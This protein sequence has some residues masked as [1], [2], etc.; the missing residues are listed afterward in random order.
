MPQFVFRSPEGQEYVVD[1]P[2]GATEDEAWAI[3]QQQLASTPSAPPQETGFFPGVEQGFRQAVGT[4]L[5]GVGELTGLEGLA[6]AGEEFG[7][8]E[9]YQPISWEETK[10]AYDEGLGEGLSATG[11][12]LREQSGQVLGG[13]APYAATTWAGAK[14]GAALMPLPQLKPIAGLAGAIA[15][16]ALSYFY[17]EDVQRQQA[18][19]EAAIARGETPPEMPGTLETLGYAGLQSGA[20]RLG[21]GVIGRYVPGINKLL[22]AEGR[23]VAEETAK[24]I[25]QQG[26]LKTTGKGAAVGIATEVPVELTQ[27]VLERQAANLPLTG[28]EANREYEEVIAATIAGVAPLG[29]VGGVA[30]RASARG[31]VERE[32]R[33]AQQAAQK[34]I[35]QEFIEPEG[36][37]EELDATDADYGVKT[38]T[39]GLGRT[40]RKTG[41]ASN[42][43]FAEQDD[44]TA[45]IQQRVQDSSAAVTI[46]R[47][48]FKKATNEA[49][50]QAGAD[51]VES[52]IVRN[53]NAQADAYEHRAAQLRAKG[54]T[55]N[56]NQVLRK[57]GKLR[58]NARARINGVRD[59]A[60]K[61][62]LLGETV[63]KMQQAQQAQA[64][65][66]PQITPEI[67]DLKLKGK[68]KDQLAQFDLSTPEGR[69]GAR[70]FLEN[71]LDKTTSG[72]M[73][74]RIMRS[75]LKLS[76][77]STYDA[78]VA[79]IAQPAPEAAAAPEVAAAPEAAPVVAEEVEEPTGL[80][81][82]EPLP[83]GL[84]E[85]VD[86][87]NSSTDEAGRAAIR[88]LA[89]S[90][91]SP[92][93]VAQAFE[94]VPSEA[95]Q[96]PV[97]V[98]GVPSVEPEVTDVQQPAG[99]GVAVAGVEPQPGAA[100]GVTAPQAGGVARGGGATVRDFGGV[101]REPST[102]DQTI[103]HTSDENVVSLLNLFKAGDVN[104]ALEL[105]SRSY[106]PLIAEVARRAMIDPPTS[107]T[108]R[109]TGNA[110][111]QYDYKK[112]EVR[113]NVSFANILLEAI[114]QG[115]NGVYQ[116]NVTREEFTA[117]KEGWFRTAAHELTHHATHS[118][119]E[120]PRT[121]AQREAVK[122]LDN[123][124]RYTRGIA[125]KDGR[126]DMYGFTTIHE[127]ISDGMSDTKF[128]DYLNSIQYKGRS[129]WTRFV[130]A[131]ADILGLEANTAFTELLNAYNVIAPQ[132]KR[133]K[134]KAAAEAVVEP[135]GE[136][137][138]Q[139]T[140]RVGEEPAGVRAGPE[141]AVSE[142]TPEVGVSEVTKSKIEA[143]K[144]NAMRGITA[145]HQRVF[146]K[147]IAGTTASE[148]RDLI[149]QV[150]SDLNPVTREDIIEANREVGRRAYAIFR[151][152]A[153]PAAVKA[154]TERQ[155][156]AVE[157]AARA[158]AEAEARIKAMV[159]EEVQ[160]SQ[161][162]ADQRRQRDELPSAY[163]VE[164]APEAA[165]KREQK[166]R[167]A[168]AIEEVLPRPQRVEGE[169]PGIAR[170]KA[171]VERVRTRTQKRAFPY[172]DATGFI[173]SLRQ[174]EKEWDPRVT[175]IN[176]IDMSDVE[177]F[178][179][180]DTDSV[181]AEYAD[182][183]LQVQALRR[184]AAKLIKLAKDEGEDYQA[185]SDALKIL[186]KS[187]SK[188]DLTE[189]VSII[190]E[191]QDILNPE[192]PTLVF[193]INKKAMEMAQRLVNGAGNEVFVDDSATT[194]TERAK[195]I[196]K[197][198]SHKEDA[199]GNKV[200]KTKKDFANDGRSLIDKAVTRMLSADAA[201]QREA[202]RR[203][204]AMT[205]N[206]AE[207]IGRALNMS[208]S[209]AYHAEALASKF[210]EL[211][212]LKYDQQAY[213]WRAEESAAN[214][215]EL[216]K[217]IQ[218]MAEKN[219]LDMMMGESLAHTYLEAARLN[220]IR[221]EEILIQRRVES[222]RKRGRPGDIKEA[223]R[224]Q[225][226][227]LPKNKKTGERT[228]VHKSLE[229]INAGLKIAEQY[230][231]V[232][233]IAETWNQIR[234]NAMK[235]VEQSGMVSAEQAEIWLDNVDYVPFY[236]QTQ[237]EAGEGPR[238][239]ISGLVSAPDRKR[240]KGTDRP[241]NNVFDNMARWTEYYIEAAVRNNSARQMMREMVGLGMA[242]QKVAVSPD[243]KA[244]RAFIWVDG[245]KTEFVADDPVWLEAFSGMETAGIPMLGMAAKFTNLLRKSVVLN[246]IFSLGQLTQ[247]SFG[248]MLSSGLP[249]MKA[250]QLPFKVIKEFVKTLNGTSKAHEELT[251][252]GTVGVKDYSAAVVR[253]EMER[254]ATNMRPNRA[255]FM[256]KAL[257]SAEHFSM[258][259]DN[260]VRQA[261]YDLSLADGV[262]KAE[263]IER[264]FEV[265]N[266]RRKGSSSFVQ[267]MARTVPFFNAYLQALNVQMNVLAGEG[268]SPRNKAQW[269]VLMKNVGM[270]VA[271]TYMYS[272]LMSGDDDYEELD[273]PM[274]DRM[275][276]IPGTG[277]FG[278]PL[279]TDLFLL[280]KILT[281]HMV[282]LSMDSAT[283]DAETFKRSVS[284]ALQHALFSPTTVPQ[285]FKPT[286]EWLLDYN[287]YTGR[288]L[289]SQRYA[290]LEPYL[291]YSPY[292]SE[293]SKLIGEGLDISPIK[294][295]NWLRGTFGS[296]AGAVLWSSNMFGSLQGVR[297]SKS[298][299]DTMATFPGLSRFINK[300]YG[301]GMRAMYYDMAREVNT[302]YKSYLNI[303]ANDPDSL[304][305][306]LARDSNLEKV[307][308]AKTM[309]DLSKKLG[310]IRK[311]QERV[312]NM[313]DVDPA[314]KRQIIEDL[315]EYE[316]QLLKSLDLKGMRK[317]I[318]M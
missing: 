76:L 14:T 317:F 114:R 254:F 89:E 131:I 175:Y 209:Q 193:S 74:D 245:K 70:D 37:E 294:L 171:A 13:L 137:A 12:F 63:S 187:K 92:E 240:L 130:Q 260:A 8:T 252:Y 208:T 182:F 302:A 189:A 72:A 233:Q 116:Q 236:R 65:A 90:E 71:I 313:R 55:K 48:N 79:A 62:A 1:G 86:L 126:A 290:D 125:K 155:Q 268:I 123:L 221:K 206:E 26:I 244:R 153:S 228:R 312:T 36:A 51:A 145:M 34:A 169:E 138:V 196:V 211:G 248:A 265:I 127:F 168:E 223:K 297:P 136:P 269:G 73:V 281:E 101:G 3:L 203:V 226:I 21:L 314:E 85:Y 185:I 17:G 120:N 32:E 200:P 64:A 119:I 57:A 292:T 117:M 271:M 179:L 289:V 243:E 176:D 118:V 104:G 28:P 151:E 214:F 202:R 277:G 264:A 95:A 96:E 78:D 177:G 2:E 207:I 45:E 93:Q 188:E 293:L 61:T 235:I 146:K 124:Y 250:I 259:S 54:A 184:K 133:V 288:Q 276:M 242:E 38:S 232:E 25:A 255:G 212:D 198:Y 112:K 251:R 201:A 52:A 159:A 279:R 191:Y 229:Q 121:K 241:V 204:R 20:E 284:T 154:V 167:T 301:S 105:I 231:E 109:D 47:T 286:V 315:Q 224:L 91:Y 142:A 27:T 178:T 305:P 108:L 24:R 113:L 19:R 218:I 166:V 9:G 253:E 309:R 29:G 15:A 316:R 49:D 190:R 295:D 66:A 53:L 270:V 161:A 238:E 222:L 257:R 261:I 180:D 220:S 115:P 150:Y 306:F 84:Q 100:E 30:Q 80:Q 83:I 210:L 285:I 215:P 106:D 310:E 156:K 139:P 110:I 94:G 6:K 234:Q 160:K 186:R 272:M 194:R 299:Q 216:I 111:G 148:M 172:V 41:V 311:Q 304:D 283:E 278:I 144:D 199:Q 35:R 42:I 227:Y 246:P 239:Y 173:K 68:A 87:Y 122:R 280:P 225:E 67:E 152:E 274:R 197:Q 300:E 164:R 143:G 174:R 303:Q 262:S 135:T 44:T 157:E 50:E 4:G 128:Q 163:K 98:R 134:P 256:T 11:R 129:L 77:D 75:K 39:T 213:K 88:S 43:A 132:A 158:E 102:L 22:G 247:D 60:L 147:P 56:A 162:E 287:F 7:Q 170:V 5:F 266:F 18:E 82:S 275:L 296:A 230:P 59:P 140:T 97:P 33:A 107:I 273:G 195:E 31:Q 205:D 249:P 46:A 298:F 183:E 219:G 103:D 16:P 181:V 81:P 307:A 318:N 263:A 58:E 282:R 165:K 308:M 23:E 141:E 217:Q 40:D 99:E 291:Q 10:A 149:D 237:I 258:A 192:E 267:F 69:V